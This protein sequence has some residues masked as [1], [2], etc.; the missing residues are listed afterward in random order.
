[1]ESLD[2]EEAAFCE[3]SARLGL[4]PFNTDGEVAD[5][6]VRA[7]ELLTGELLADFLDSVDPS[8]IGP[9]LN[10]VSEASRSIDDLSAPKHADLTDLRDELARLLSLPSNLDPWKAGL[11]T[12]Q[13]ARRF[14][15]HATTERLAVEDFV[16]RSVREVPDRRVDGYGGTMGGTRL[17]LGRNSSSPSIRFACARALWHGLVDAPGSTFLLTRAPTVRQK[18]GR[19]FAAEFLA[20]AAGIEDMLQPIGWFYSADDVEEIADR[21]GVSTLVIEHQ[22]D[23]NVRLRS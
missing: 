10:W 14:L 9:T 15:N 22:I 2:R 17:V 7:G 20:P 18:A 23:N 3:A 12:A 5:D 6:V 4:D 16:S 19:A 21:Y 13:A 8:N 1:L 11:A